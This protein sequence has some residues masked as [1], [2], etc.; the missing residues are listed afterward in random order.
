MQ[1]GER[2]H[3]ISHYQCNATSHLF[4]DARSGTIVQLRSLSPCRAWGEGGRRPGEGRF[5]AMYCDLFA[6]VR[7]A[8]RD[9]YIA[10]DA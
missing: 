10:F 9:G 6:L 8:C 7:R 3:L 5:F 1:Q 4:F 2:E